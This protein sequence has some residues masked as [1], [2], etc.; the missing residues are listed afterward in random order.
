[1]KQ[2]KCIMSFIRLV[3]ILPVTKHIYLSRNTLIIFLD[4]E[5]QTRIIFYVVSDPRKRSQVR[6]EFAVYVLQ[7]IKGIQSSFSTSFYLC[8]KD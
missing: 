3:I 2:K 7:E 5:E 1:M 8:Q 4:K 6:L